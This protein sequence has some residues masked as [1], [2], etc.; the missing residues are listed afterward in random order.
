MQYKALLLDIDGT[1]VLKGFKNLPS[2]KVKNAIQSI[3][4][5]VKICL[6]TGRPLKTADP[7][8]Q[9]LGA[10]D[11][12]ILNGGGTLF[13]THT[14]NIIEACYLPESTV[15]K[16]VE[17]NQNLYDR[18]ILCTPLADI[19]L[20]DIHDLTTVTGF[21]FVQLTP[22]EVEKI[23][24]KLKRVEGISFHISTQTFDDMPVAVVTNILG[25][26]QQAIEHAIKILHV[27]PEEIVA[28][29]DGENDI[30]MILA[31]G[32]GVAM[33][34]AAEGLKSVADYIAPSV[35]DDGLAHVIEKF[36]LN[37]Q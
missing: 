17:D 21:F 30:P 16:I 5:K 32:M 12:C 11:L 20:Q 15:K 31:A 8:I 7:V 24:E 36:F 2:E 27:H 28:V 14:R 23:I 25:T 4:G 29:G 13:D 9:A 19:Y 3:Q 34:N 1:V 26:K 18:T 37:Q 22:S 33:G 6:A 10:I 35:E